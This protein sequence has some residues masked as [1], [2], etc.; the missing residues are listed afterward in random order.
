M[1]PEDYIRRILVGQTFAS[2]DAELEEIREGRKR[3]ESILRSHFSSSSPSIR[4]AGS[5]AKGTMIR[6]SYDGDMTCYFDHDDVSAGST[7]AEIYSNT[8]E[9]LSGDYL[10]EQKPSAIR[11]RDK[12]FHTDLHIDV[13]P[14]RYTNDERKDVFL[15]RTT[16]DKER[17]KTNLQVHVDHIKGSGVVD[18]IRLMKLWNVRNGVD[19]KTFVLELLVVELLREQ[20]RTSLSSQLLSVWREFSDDPDGLAVEDPANANNDLKPVLDRFRPMLEQAARDTLWQID[21]SGWEA[22][23]GSIEDDD[24]GNGGKK[25]EALRATAAAVANPT[26]PWLIGF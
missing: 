14:G 21:N 11:V 6:E 2:D 10:L 17:L 18:A 19:T 4:W 22:V 3:I 24:G 25:R 7:L 23:F 20:K 9:A 12:E 16:G 8:L 15:H 13:V 26:K 1:K 5:M